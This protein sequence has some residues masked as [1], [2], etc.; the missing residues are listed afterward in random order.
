MG[1]DRIWLFYRRATSIKSR[2]IIFE[3]S[4]VKDKDISIKFDC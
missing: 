2:A 3:D 1:T 4:R